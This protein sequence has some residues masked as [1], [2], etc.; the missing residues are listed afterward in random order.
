M[1]GTKVKVEKSLYNKIKMYSDIAGYSSVE[2]FVHHALEKEIEQFEG[3]D[4][5]E[6]IREKLK[7]LGYIS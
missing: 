1:F 6:E 5:E 4:S 3:A 7:G 2:E